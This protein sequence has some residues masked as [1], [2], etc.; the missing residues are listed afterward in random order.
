M[1]VVRRSVPKGPLLGLAVIMI[2]AAVA[3]VNVI[4]S[5][6]HNLNEPGGYDRTE[7]AT[8]GEPLPYDRISLSDAAP[9]TG[10]PLTDGRILF[11]ANDCASCHGLTGQGATV[12]EDG[13]DTSDISAAEF[14]RDLRK[15][16]KGMPAFIEEALSDEEAERLYSFLDAVGQEGSD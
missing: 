16:P 1:G 6:H 2:M 14:L 11:F 8:L 9:I 7:V 15:G 10:D 13:L 5:P 12:A 3:V 4:R